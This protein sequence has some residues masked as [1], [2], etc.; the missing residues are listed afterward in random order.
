MRI[1][2]LLDPLLAERPKRHPRD[3]YISTILKPTSWGGAIELTIF[4]AHFG[5]EIASVDV[6]SGRVDVFAAP[7]GATNTGNRC[8]LI[9][10]G[11]HYDA[12]SL[13]PVADAPP[14]WHQTVFSAAGAPESD[15]VLGSAKKLATILRGKR[16]YTNTSTFDLKCEVGVISARREC[17]LEGADLWRVCVRY[18]SRG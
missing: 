11:I 1:Y 14:E 7:P 9:Y 12:A 10:S 4:A 8:V 2:I 6:E 18:A 13:A 5:T 17:C 16:A 15:P 3:Q